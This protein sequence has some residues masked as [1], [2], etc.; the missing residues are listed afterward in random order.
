M[1][2]IA[3]T[4]AFSAAFFFS[5][6]LVG[7][8]VTSLLEQDIAFGHKRDDQIHS[9][10]RRNN[11]STSIYALTEYAAIVTEYVR[12]S[13]SL[14]DTTL[15]QDFQFAWRNHMKA[16]REHA[17]FL[18]QAEESF[19]SEDI[20]RSEFFEVFWKQDREITNTWRMVEVFGRKYGANDVQY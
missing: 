20:N 15:P 13:E 18:N 9:L 4:I 7:Q 11:S 3:A 12:K 5:T 6:L 2:H 8:S 14:D 19:F 16:W 17:N 10:Y 1:K